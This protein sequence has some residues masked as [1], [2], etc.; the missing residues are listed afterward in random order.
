[1]KKKIVLN[2][3]PRSISQAKKTLQ[4]YKQG[5]NQGINNSVES[6]TE[7][8]Y[9]KVIKKCEEANL[10]EFINAIQYE[11]DKNTNIGRVWV[12]SAGKGS[13]GFIIILNEFGTGIKGDAKS[14]A[15]KHGY[16]INKSGKGE[17]GWP[18]PTKDG[19]FKW[20][21]GIRSKRMFYES[22]DEIREEFKDIINVELLGTI[23]NLYERTE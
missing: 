10:G 11:Y 22:Y 21:H 6:A 7:K 9:K 15:E 13:N 12:T 4:E 8:L 3:S 16:T 20:T 23:G 17:K 19:E 14:Y 1:M 5:F 2:L 18:F